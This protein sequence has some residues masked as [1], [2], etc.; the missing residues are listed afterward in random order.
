MK[1]SLHNHSQVSRYDSTM[2]V[3][4]LCKRAKECG[5]EAIALT[6]HGTLTG[7]DDFIDCRWK[8]WH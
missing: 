2:N 6:D 5:Y 8:I 4:A 7:I 3:E 1:G